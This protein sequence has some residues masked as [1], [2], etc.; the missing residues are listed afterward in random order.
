MELNL[1]ELVVKLKL[2]KEGRLGYLRHGSLMHIASSSNIKV[3]KHG[4]FRSK[5]YCKPARK[6]LGEVT[7]KDIQGSKYPSAES[8]AISVEEKSREVVELIYRVDKA[9]Y[10]DLQKKIISLSD[11]LSE[12]DIMIDDVFHFDSEYRVYPIRVCRICFKKYFKQ[13]E[14]EV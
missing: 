8:Y 10:R 13:L 9:S 14:V 12:V 11:T 7:I 3:N 4:F 5:V 2:Q 1:K 6:V